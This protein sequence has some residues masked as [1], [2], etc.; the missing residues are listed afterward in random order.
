MPCWGIPICF[1][2]LS[3]IDPMLERSGIMKNTLILIFLLFI[4]SSLNCTTKQEVP[5]AK[6]FDL[7]GT[8]ILTE[9]KRG[10]G[11]T[12]TTST[13]EVIQKG[14]TVTIVDSENNKMLGKLYSDSILI[15]GIKTLS[16]EG[17]VAK[18]METRDHTLKISEDANKL[19]GK[20]K[21]TLTSASSGNCDGITILAYKR[22]PWYRFWN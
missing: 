10:C 21:F 8:W 2:R 14:D 5:E 1:C 15:A 18:H 16:S 7:S 9:D 3:K 13:V 19:T 22:K 20:V 11:D 6:T 4:L 17:G 12:T